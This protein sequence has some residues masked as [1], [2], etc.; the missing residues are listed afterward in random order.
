MALGMLLKQARLDAGLSQRQ[1]CGEEI[2][3][4]MLSQIE[5]GAARPSMDTLRYLAARLGKPVSYFLEEETASANQS[6][7]QQA[8]IA[9]TAGAYDRV[10]ELLQD[11][12]KPD[13]VFDGEMGLLQAL[14]TMEKAKQAIDRGKA[15][16]AAA[17]LQEMDTASLY[18][19]PELQ[20]RRLLLL[21]QAQ[22]SYARQ[23]VQQLPSDDA[24]LLLRARAAQ[25]DGE[26]QKALRL[27]DAVEKQTEEWYFLKGEALAAMGDFAQAAACFK[28]V[29]DRALAQLESCYEQL[30]DY[31]AAYYYAK[32]QREK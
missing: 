19:V 1:L 9:Y 11:Y 8:K 29:E 14:A 26:T 15:P 13:T 30:G 20:R 27:L 10:L 12:Q 28:Q 7:M 16:Y 2:T 23:L 3:R 24:A 18:F 17:L 6:L 5:N 4:N 32:K 31:K 25:E 21:A 22:P